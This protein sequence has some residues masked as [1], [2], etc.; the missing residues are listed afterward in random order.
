MS[1][2]VNEASTRLKLLGNMTV[3]L[4]TFAST[5][6]LGNN[7]KFRVKEL[8]STLMSSEKMK[9]TVKFF[10]VGSILNSSPR[11]VRFIKTP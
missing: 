4:Q 9:V 6:R 7:V 11:L 1:L 2:Y 10:G 8:F 5:G 3:V